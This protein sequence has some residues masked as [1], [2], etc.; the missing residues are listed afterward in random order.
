MYTQTNNMNLNVHRGKC[1]RYHTQKNRVNLN[2]H[3]DEQ[4]KL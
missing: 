2:M 1:N 4:C 3:T